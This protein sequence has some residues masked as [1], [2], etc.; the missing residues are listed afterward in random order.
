MA[1]NTYFQDEELEQING[2]TLL[3][4]L[5]LLSPHKYRVALS[6][7]LVAVAS[8]ATLLGPYLVKIAVDKYI[9]E[10]DLLGVIRLSVL[11]ILVLIISHPVPGLINL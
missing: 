7:G 2:H 8:I 9:P 1:R 3:R 11:Y 5:R 4:L 10:K 6:L